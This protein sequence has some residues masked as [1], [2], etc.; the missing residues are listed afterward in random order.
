MNILNLLYYLKGK[1]Y[2]FKR[3]IIKKYVK[4]FNWCI[5]HLI[6]HPLHFPAKNFK[7]FINNFQSFFKFYKKYKN[8]Y[9]LINLFI[10]RLK[11]VSTYLLYDF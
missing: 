2:Y 11:N 10:L 9:T 8:A 1:I 5:N 3:Y 4:I 7:K 6:N